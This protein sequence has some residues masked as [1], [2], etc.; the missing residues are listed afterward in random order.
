MSS[1]QAPWHACS[2]PQSVTSSGVAPDMFL[3]SSGD[4][5][6][7]ASLCSLS[8]PST[9]QFTTVRCHLGS[10]WHS[11]RAILAPCCSVVWCLCHSFVPLL[12]PVAVYPTRACDDSKVVSSFC[13]QAV[14]H[15]FV[16][17][18]LTTCWSEQSTL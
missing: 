5:T 3:S 11:K 1:Q 15:N 6:M 18:C 8:A 9:L 14:L 12:V 17:P 10:A 2:H 4:L 16:P 13:T 7:W